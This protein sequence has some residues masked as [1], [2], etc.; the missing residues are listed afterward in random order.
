MDPLSAAVL[1]EKTSSDA[2]VPQ[3]SPAQPTMSLSQSATVTGSKKSAGISGTATGTGSQISF[4]STGTGVGFS[5]ASSMSS[6]SSGGIETRVSCVAIIGKQNNPIYIRTFKDERY[7]S[8]TSSPLDKLKY[9]YIVHT[10]L[11]AVEEKCIFLM[12][13]YF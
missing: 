6:G 7:S 1:T 4:S 10:S 2:A 11:D 8:M 13:S 5:S 9:H 3:Q 12:T